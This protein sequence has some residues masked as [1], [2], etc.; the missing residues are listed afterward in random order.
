[1]ISCQLSPDI[2]QTRQ[3]IHNNWNSVIREVLTL[4][5]RNNKLGTLDND[6]ILNEAMEKLHYFSSSKTSFIDI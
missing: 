2:K 1:M 3:T 6:I 5:T 4:E